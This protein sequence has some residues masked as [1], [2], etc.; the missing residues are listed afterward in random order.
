MK[1]LLL[2]ALTTTL[3][4]CKP[5]APSSGTQPGKRNVISVSGMHCE[6]CEIAIKQSVMTCDG[7]NDVAASASDEEVVVW[8]ATGTDL[9]AVKSKIA[10]LG[11]KVD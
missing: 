4:S 11:F 1:Y 2:I 9:G 7:V 10:S 8:V 6:N 5:H 3:V